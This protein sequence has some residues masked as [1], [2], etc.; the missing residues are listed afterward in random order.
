[1]TDHPATTIRVVSI[2]PA[3]KTKVRIVMELIADVH[4]LAEVG[5]DMLHKA[6]TQ[7]REEQASKKK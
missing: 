1:M 5:S 3:G 2:E 7:V 6:I 4:R